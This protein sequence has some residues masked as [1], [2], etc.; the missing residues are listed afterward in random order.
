MAAVVG[1]GGTYGCQCGIL[2]ATY[3]SIDIPPI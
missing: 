2:H 1:L 3:K